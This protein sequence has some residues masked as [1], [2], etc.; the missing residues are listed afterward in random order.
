[1]QA[2]QAWQERYDEIISGDGWLSERVKRNAKELQKLYREAWKAVPDER[3]E[4]ILRACEA[5]CYP[6]KPKASMENRFEFAKLLLDGKLDEYADEIRRCL[7]WPERSRQYSREDEERRR[8]DEEEKRKEIEEWNTPENVAARLA[9]QEE[10]EE[11]RLAKAA[12]MAGESIAANADNKNCSVCG[13]AV[14]DPVSKLRGVGPE[15]W[16][17]VIHRAVRDGTFSNKL[18][19]DGMPPWLE[20]DIARHK[21]SIELERKN[22]ESFVIKPGAKQNVSLGEWSKGRTGMMTLVAPRLFTWAVAGTEIRKASISYGPYAQHE[23]CVGVHYSYPRGNK[24]FG[25]QQN[26][27]DPLTALMI[28][29]GYVETPKFEGCDLASTPREEVKAMLNEQADEIARRFEVLFDWRDWI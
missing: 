13:K 2:T 16:K 17:R 29:A 25:R 19:P 20:E 7:E 18:F 27:S 6:R 15:C 22:R 4:E 28:V 12:R 24:V 23:R 10:W 1:M 5:R 14:T 3:K 8:R 26:A 9:K 11:E 21:R